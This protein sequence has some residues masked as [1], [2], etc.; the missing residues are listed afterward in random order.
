[1]K[2]NRSEVITRN[3]DENSTVEEGLVMFDSLV[4]EHF[5]AGVFAEDFQT[6]ILDLLR[7]RKFFGPAFDHVSK[8]R[9]EISKF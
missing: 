7:F 1:M 8:K 9:K 2:R 4:E 5:I 3:P 6:N